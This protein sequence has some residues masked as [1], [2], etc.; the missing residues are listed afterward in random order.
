MLSET[1]LMLLYQLLND[2]DRCDSVLD[3]KLDPIVSKS[4]ATLPKKQ[5]A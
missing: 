1:C 5:Q 3:E 2:S 4:N